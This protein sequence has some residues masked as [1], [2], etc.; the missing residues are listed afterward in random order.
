[1]NNGTRYGIS[2]GRYVGYQF[3]GRGYPHRYKA[4]QAPFRKATPTIVL[5]TTR[6]RDTIA[7]VANREAPL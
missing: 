7:S 5:E 2:C 1:M 4:C 3:L 6:E